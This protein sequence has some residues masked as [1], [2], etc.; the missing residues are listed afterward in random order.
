[1]QNIGHRCE[2]CKRRFSSQK[3]RDRFCPECRD[4]INKKVETAKSLLGIWIRTHKEQ[5]RV[6]QPLHGFLK[7]IDTAGTACTP[8]EIKNSFWE[9]FCCP[10]CGWW[11]EKR[12]F[13]EIDTDDP[14]GLWVY[15]EEWTIALLRHR[16]RHA[17][18]GRFLSSRRFT[19]DWL[20]ELDLWKKRI[21]RFGFNPQFLGALQYENRTG[22]PWQGAFA[23]GYVLSDALRTL[24]GGTSEE[25]RKPSGDPFG[26]DLKSFLEEN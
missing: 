26:R 11:G 12:R 18:P 13:D 20:R 1:M 9:V 5:A 2:A 16:A 17:F 3:S 4:F 21:E 8:E 10:L 23:Q 22:A 25:P 14:R 19:P 6:R 7:G 24:A 15:V